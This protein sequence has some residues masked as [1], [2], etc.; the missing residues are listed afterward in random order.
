MD[1]LVGTTSTA[2]DAQATLEWL[3]RLGGKWVVKEVNCPQQDN[4]FDCGIF[5]INFAIHILER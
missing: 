2:E 3:V 5:V 4:G 1:S